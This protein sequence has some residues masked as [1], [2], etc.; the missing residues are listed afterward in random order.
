MTLHL[1]QKNKFG[2][3]EGTVMTN[4]T[5]I[6]ALQ[7]LC[8]SITAPRQ[9]TKLLHSFKHPCHHL[10]LLFLLFLLSLANFFN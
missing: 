6:E 1:T 3:D 7:Q 5:E 8:V 9:A 10:L 2:E 4:E